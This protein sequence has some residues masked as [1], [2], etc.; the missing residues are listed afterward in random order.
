MELHIFIKGKKEPEVFKGDR[1]D[2]LDLSMLGINYKQ[3][4]CFKNGI[5]KSELVEA[6]LINKILEK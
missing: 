1:I 3:I 4:R 6:S 2:V 5:S